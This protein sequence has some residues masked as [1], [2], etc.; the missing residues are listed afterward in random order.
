M[1]RT[2]YRVVT[3]SS[4]GD[5][6][7]R[8]YT[9]EEELL[10]RHIQVGVNDYTLDLGL[11]G[12]PIFK[13]LIGPMPESNGIVRYESPDVFEQLTKEWADAKRKRRPRMKKPV[14]VLAQ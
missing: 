8:D 6:R 5:Y 14:E 1:K 9:S 12:C 4:N 13:G 2:I 7:I 11:R 3:T 10:K